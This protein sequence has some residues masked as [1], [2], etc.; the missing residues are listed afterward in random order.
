MGQTIRLLILFPYIFLVPQLSSAIVG[1]TNFVDTSK[2]PSVCRIIT[3]HS[4]GSPSIC[5]AFLIAP[6]LVMTAAHCISPR[7]DWLKEKVDIKC[8]QSGFD[9]KTTRLETTRKGTP[10]VADGVA[11]D[12]TLRIVSHLQDDST[13]QAILRLATMSS[14]KPIKLF[15]PNVGS[16]KQ[17][18]ISGYGINNQ[19]YA[20]FIVS[21]IT[22]IPSLHEEKYL[23]TSFLKAPVH[24]NEPF[25]D[26]DKDPNAWVKARNV[27]KNIS[28]N[29]ISAAIGTPGDSGGPLICQTKNGEVGAIGVFLSVQVVNTMGRDDF[30]WVWLSWFSPINFNLL[31]KSKSL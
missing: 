22:N 19:N 27:L 3:R 17:C 12:E 29:K 15:A 6:N 18:W 14:Q 1:N 10:L 4:D 11:F 13:D 30:D 7:V 21:S 5:T 9:K 16:L 20:G 23:V 8:G 26:F 24:L 31:Q 25:I 28:N 2:M